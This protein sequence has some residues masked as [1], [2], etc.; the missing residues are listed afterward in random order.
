MI[1][2]SSDFLHGFEWSRWFTRGWTLQELL[3]PNTVVFYDKD[4]FEIVTWW[5]LRAQISGATGMKYDSMIR[6]KDASI[7]TKMS[8]ASKRSTTRVEDVAYCLMGLFD[9]HMPLLYGEGQKAFMRLQY[10]IVQSRDDD[11]SIFAWT[12]ALLST[13]GMFA[14]SPAAFA[15]SG[16]IRC[17]RNPNPRASPPVVTRTSLLL[18]GSIP[19]EGSNQSI[20]LVLN[21][22]RMGMDSEF[23]AIEVKKALSGYYL[24]S[25]PE[26]LTACRFL[27]CADNDPP[28]NLDVAVD[29]LQMSLYCTE[30]K[31]EKDTSSKKQQTV[32]IPTQFSQGHGLRLDRIFQLKEVYML[33][34]SLNAPKEYLMNSAMAYRDGD[35]LMEQRGY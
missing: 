35:S 20:L 29:K 18:E 19:T 17:V 5:S 13:S 34:P 10:E 23:L 9:I 16:D 8:W 11:E 4:W 2:V 28:M 26:Q 30:Y 22:A 25:S 32:L 24:R 21:C 33:Y 15:D 27:R 14:Q 1:D 7:A 12:D 31:S 6:P 3:A